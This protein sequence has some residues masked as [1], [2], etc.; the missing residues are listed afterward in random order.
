MVDKNILNSVE[1]GMVAAVRPPMQR[2]STATTVK[3]KVE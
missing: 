2:R 3:N 1:P